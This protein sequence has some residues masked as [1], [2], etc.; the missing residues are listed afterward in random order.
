MPYIVVNE[1]EA[2]CPG[3]QGLRPPDPA[4]SDT[5]RGTQH[6]RTSASQIGACYRGEPNAAV[7]AP[8]P[9]KWTVGILDPWRPPAKLKPMLGSATGDTFN[10]KPMRDEGRWRG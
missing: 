3:Q 7:Q 9:G 10:S 8:P 6:W 1:S 2:A 4:K 5:V